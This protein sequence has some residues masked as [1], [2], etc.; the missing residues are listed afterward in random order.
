MTQPHD[1]PDPMDLIGAVRAFLADEVAAATTGQVSFHARVAA[2]V[3]ALVEREL[4]NGP[5][6]AERHASR[7]AALGAADDANLA[8]RIRSGEFDDRYDE[9]APLLRAA[10][11]DKLQVVNPKY[12]GEHTSSEAREGT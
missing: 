6:D 8:A 3:L 9:I 11:W 10:V 7:L 4:T 2:N 5:A 1:R 12:A